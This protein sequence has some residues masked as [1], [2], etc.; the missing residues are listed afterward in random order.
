VATARPRSAKSRMCVRFGIGRRI[1]AGANGYEV[2]QV[3]E[4]RF[5][6]GTYPVIL[7]VGAF[8]PLDEQEAQRVGADGVLKKPV[9]ATRSADLDGEVSLMARRM[10]L[11][12]QSGRGDRESRCAVPGCGRRTATVS[13]PNGTV[14]SAACSLRDPERRAAYRAVICRGIP[15]K[16]ETLNIESAG[17]AAWRRKA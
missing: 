14:V 1:H 2:L 8:D 7:L 16:P 9:C 17:Q 10:R 15:T 3:R 11:A 13:G 5:F 4:G 12:R 6:A